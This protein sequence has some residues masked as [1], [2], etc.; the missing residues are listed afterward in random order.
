MKPTVMEVAKEFAKAKGWDSD[1]DIEGTIKI[2]TDWGKEVWADSYIETH[3]WYSCQEVVVQLGD[4]FIS[5][6]QYIITG[7][8]GMGDMGLEYD[9]ADFAIV[10]AKTRTIT[11]TYYE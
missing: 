10:T 4:Y 9:I 2:I 11:E 1:L 7:D 8:V 6:D 3:R 5:F